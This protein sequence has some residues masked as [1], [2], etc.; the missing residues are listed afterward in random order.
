MYRQRKLLTRDRN[1][2]SDPPPFA[3]RHARDTTTG[4]TWCFTLMGGPM[5]PGGEQRRFSLANWC[6]ER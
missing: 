6:H 2:R 3:F 5:G 1:T 4:S